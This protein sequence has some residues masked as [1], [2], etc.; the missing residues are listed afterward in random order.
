MLQEIAYLCMPTGVYHEVRLCHMWVQLKSGCFLNVILANIFKHMIRFERYS[1]LQSN[2]IRILAPYLR[3]TRQVNARR[4]IELIIANR[5]I[6]RSSSHYFLFSKRYSS[7]F[8]II[9]INYAPTGSSSSTTL[10]FPLI[11]NASMS[12][13]SSSSSS[14]ICC[15]C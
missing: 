14:S 12:G 15:V 10:F 1:R 13:I 9:T 3:V 6:I 4:L 2:V 8:I 7:L 11:A 5:D